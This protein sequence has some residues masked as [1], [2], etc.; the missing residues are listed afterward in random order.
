MKQLIKS[1]LAGIVL[2]LF[3]ISVNAKPEPTIE[4]HARRYD[5]VPAEITLRK[6]QAVKLLLISDDVAHSLKIDVLHLNVKIPVGKNIETTVTP[7]E[8]GDFKGTCGVFCG[9]GHGKMT[10]GVHVVSGK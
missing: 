2:L 10:L 3:S 7:D 4:I 9:S 5:F 8:V 6:G 1:A